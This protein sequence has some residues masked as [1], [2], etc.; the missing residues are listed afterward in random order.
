MF[1][2]HK[3]ETGITSEAATGPAKGYCA[4]LWHHAEERIQVTPALLLA[5]IVWAMI[6]MMQLALL[7]LVHIRVVQV[8]LPPMRVLAP[9]AVNTPLVPV[10]GYLLVRIPVLALF[11]RVAKLVWTASKVLHIVRVNALASI[12]VALLS[13]ERTPHGFEMEHVE[14]SVHF[15]VV[16]QVYG[17]VVF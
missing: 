7:L 9:E 1:L 16:E 15:H 2:L 6:A 12:V 11:S 3:A 17:N 13:A 10:S 5:V 4:V 14:I 8:L